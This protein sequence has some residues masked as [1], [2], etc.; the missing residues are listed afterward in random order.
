MREISS[1]EPCPTPAGRIRSADPSWI[2]LL[3]TVDLSNETDRIGYRMP[4]LVGEIWDNVPVG[5][6]DFNAQ[7]Y[8]D[9]RVIANHTY[10][11]APVP[12]ESGAA[13]AESSVGFNF[14]GLFSDVYAANYAIGRNTSDNIIEIEHALA[15][16]NLLSTY[17]DDSATS[18]GAGI[19]RTQLLITFPTKYRHL[20]DVCRSGVA[21]PAGFSWYPPFEIS[22]PY[23]PIVYSLDIWDNQ[24]N[25][26]Q[27]AGIVWSG[28]NVAK[29]ELPLEVNYFIPSWPITNKNADGSVNGVNFESGWFNMGLVARAGCSYSGV[30]VLSFSHKYST[31]G[32]SEVG[33]NNSWFVPV[34]HKPD[35]TNR[36]YPRK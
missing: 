36:E 12:K 9:G 29:D 8:F 30:P 25:N 32:Q 2:K 31:I 27:G 24:E 13:V 15:A 34:S 28:E 10:D 33:I 6:A 19:N 18:T 20:S 35:A 22:K 16:T 23:G 17:E 21:L 5:I 26:K 14:G 7:P 11:V 4:A 3:A 1:G